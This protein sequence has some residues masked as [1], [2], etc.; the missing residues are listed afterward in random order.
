MGKKYYYQRPL[1]W[2]DFEMLMKGLDNEIEHT[3]SEGLASTQTAIAIGCYL[4]PRP[5]ELFAMN[6]N[7]LTGRMYSF[8][9]ETNRKALPIE[10]PLR[11]IIEKNHRIINPD[12]SYSLIL[13]DSIRRSYEPITPNKFN[14]RLSAVFDKYGI[15]TPDPNVE[16]L[17]KTFARKKWLDSDRSDDVIREL[18]QE[19]L[20]DFN[21]MLKYVSL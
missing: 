1:P 20:I 2:E 18:S 12:N 16:T 14:K 9:T 8:R 4:G 5:A 13:I 7:H 6:W 17:R 10:A 11:N 21:V 19:F 3:Q 15:V